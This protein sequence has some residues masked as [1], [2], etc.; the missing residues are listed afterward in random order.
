MASNSIATYKKH[1]KCLY[2]LGTPSVGVL[3]FLFCKICYLVKG[4]SWVLWFLLTHLVERVAGYSPVLNSWGHSYVFHGGR[5]HFQGLQN[6]HHHSVVCQ[7]EEL[8]ATYAKLGFQDSPFEFWKS[9]EGI[10]AISL[11]SIP[12][13]GNATFWKEGQQLEQ[14][15]QDKS[16]SKQWVQNLSVLSLDGSKVAYLKFT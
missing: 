6:E 15:T 1:W 13:N 16:H 2:W 7:S 11:Q 12:R 9:T 14:R 4:S 5:L 3:L 8:H 10:F